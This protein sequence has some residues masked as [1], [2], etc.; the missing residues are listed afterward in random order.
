VV[1]ETRADES[2][3]AMEAMVED[4]EDAEEELRSRVSTTLQ[5]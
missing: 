5:E 1:V 2:E 4:A 3:E